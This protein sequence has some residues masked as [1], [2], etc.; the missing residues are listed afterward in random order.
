[1]RGR[2]SEHPVAAEN[3]V[4]KALLLIAL[5]L[6]RSGIDGQ[7]RIVTSKGGVDEFRSIPC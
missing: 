2:I 6:R 4:H 1:M 7:E 5:A 3:Q